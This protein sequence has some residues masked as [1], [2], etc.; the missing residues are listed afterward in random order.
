MSFGVAKAPALSQ[1]LMRKILSIL[2]GR[3]VVQ[4][5][6]SQGAQIEAQINDVCLET[7]TQQDHS[8]PL[9]EFIAVCKDNHPR[10]KLE[11]CQY[12]QETVQYLGFNIGYG[13]WAQAAS[14][15]KPLM[16]AKVRHE[17]PKKGPM[18][19]AASLGRPTWTGGT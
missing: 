16:D 15:A 4:E 10:L 3:S 17:D 9:G 14:K 8:I 11:K 18:M 13:W 2:H 7:K 1:E 12:M 6:T 5:L 19:Y